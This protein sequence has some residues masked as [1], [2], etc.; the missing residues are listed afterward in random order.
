MDQYN[1]K[2]LKDCDFEV[3]QELLRDT[4]ELLELLEVRVE[5]EERFLFPKFE[6]TPD[7]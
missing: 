6:S 7:A 1:K 4:T 3:S 5:R 2:W